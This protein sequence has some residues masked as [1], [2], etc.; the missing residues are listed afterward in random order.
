MT[1]LHIAR[2]YEPEQR[3]ALVWTYEDPRRSAKDVVALAAAGELRGP[4]GRRL[5]PFDVNVASLRSIV[6][7]HRQRL[8]PGDIE[9]ANTRLL[10]ELLRVANTELRALKAV[11]AGKRDMRKVAQLV[12]VQARIDA[13]LQGAPT[14]K[15]VRMPSAEPEH[16]MGALMAA[17]REN[18]GGG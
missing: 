9:A 15:P 1:D 10:E 17:H 18:G 4:D 3:A 14:P 7:R 8:A 2:V 6:R 13:S 16:A 11:K 12:T 5:P